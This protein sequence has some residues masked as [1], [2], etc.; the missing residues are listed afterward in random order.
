MISLATASDR[1]RLFEVWEASVR[2]THAFLSEE[3]IQALAPLVRAEL[4][5]AAAI[6]CVRDAEGRACAFMIVEGDAIEG[7]FVAPEHRGAGVGRALVEHAVNSL[8][9]RRVDV[10]EQNPRAVGFYQRMGFR[11]ASRSPL[12][13]QGRAFPILHMTLR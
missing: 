9:A 4:A 6:R 2:A 11:V 5:R 12:D 8:G 7:L 3:D 13:G 1:P 10:N